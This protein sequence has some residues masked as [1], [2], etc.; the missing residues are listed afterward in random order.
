MCAWP[1]GAGIAALLCAHQQQ[2]Q[3][4]VPSSA[5]AAPLPPLR[6]AILVSGYVPPGAEAQRLLSQAGALRVP[7]LHIYST[8][9]GPGDAIS[10]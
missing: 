8:R 10:E 1:Q 4:D 3:H 2:Q 7:S 9:N 6:F 5:A